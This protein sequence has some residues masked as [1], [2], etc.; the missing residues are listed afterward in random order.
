MGMTE[1]VNNTCTVLPPLPG[2]HGSGVRVSASTL[3]A[4]RPPT[5]RCAPGTLLFLYLPY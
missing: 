2:Q 1:Y 5:A 3:L 4:R